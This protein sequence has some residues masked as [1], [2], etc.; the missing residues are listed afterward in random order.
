MSVQPFDPLDDDAPATKAQT[1]SSLRWSS[2][3]VSGREGIRIVFG[4]LL[5]A[6]L[7]PKNYGIVGQA[8]VY[9][10][11]TS[12]FIDQ[13]FSAALI[14]FRRVTAAHQS[15]VFVITLAAA[16]AVA[17]VTLTV[18]PLLADFFRTEELTAVLGVLAIGTALKGFMV[19]PHAMMVRR[20][21][22][23][24]LAISEL[25][26]AVVSGIAGVV[27][28][29]MG[30][31]YW[32]LVVMLMVYDLWTLVWWVAAAGLPRPT[33]SR[34]A[35]DEIWGFS[36][37]SMGA[38]LVNYA[39]R[40]LDNV[41][42]ARVLGPVALAYYSLSYRV[43]MLPVQN[44]G[45]VVTR[46]TLPVYSRLQDDRA[47]LRHQYLLGTHMLAV[48]SF[49]PMILLIVVAP[50]AVPL[51]LGADWEPAVVPMQILALTGMRQ[52]ASMLGS[53]IVVACGR[54][55]WHFRFSMVTA[56]V[57]I[58][59]FFIGV[60][61]GVVGV[62]A[63]YTISSALMMP[64]LAYMTGKLV[65][66]Y[67]RDWLRALA[68]AAS[69]GLVAVVAGSA[70]LEALQRGGGGDVPA[71]LGGAA[72]VL[73]A[74]AVVLRLAWRKDWDV[75]RDMVAVLL[76]RPGRGKRSAAAGAIA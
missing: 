29:R 30:A 10:A 12:L 5:A 27:A 50:V 69:A 57:T 72:A 16:M 41:I 20:M 2:L 43:M 24:T 48:A 56:A 61:W 66:A 58:T 45:R 51:L 31:E 33:F 1:A 63:A 28:A 70:A 23:R 65:G 39:S 53:N 52:T 73:V 15:T 47:R 32:A 42:I 64:V 76:H 74:F 36:A 21:E 55:D 35:F 54:A 11:L 3:G 44:V 68:P 7:G 13:G 37:N 34:Q 60:N 22:F 46:V 40:N 18:A 25:S 38:Q 49:P 71:M 67:L 75:A 62:A 4:L 17:G 9:T 8:T 26:G 6:W 14:R 59:S 19:V